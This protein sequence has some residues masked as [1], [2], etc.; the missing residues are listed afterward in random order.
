M[1]T[2]EQNVI[3]I[4][5][6]SK[7]KRFLA[8]L[9]DYFITF[10]ISFI[11][12]NLLVFPVA[13]VICDTQSKSREAANY[14][15]QALKMLNE[16]GFLKMPNEGASFEDSVNYSFK[17][18]LSY[19]AFDTE[20]VDHNYPDYGHK[21]N[22]EVI[23]T[24]YENVVNDTQRYIQDF[25]EVNATNQ[26]FDI[27]DTV[28]TIVLK[29][30]YKAIL[31][32]ELLEVLDESEYSLAM[33]NFRDNVFARLF[34][35]K[36]YNNILENDYVKNNVSYLSLLNESKEIMNG[37]K[38]VPSVS[39]LISILLSWSVTFILYPL[40][41]KE[42]RTITMS[43]MRLNKLHYKS[44]SFIDN[45]NVLFQSFYHFVLI[46]S[47][48]VFMP[49]L[50]FGISYCFNLPLLFVLSIISLLLTLV[51]MMFVFFNEHN[52][53]GMDILTNVVYIESNEVDNMYIENIKNGK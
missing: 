42:K 1:E 46:L 18:F 25:K 27:G 41:N 44:L 31:S 52:R 28:D 15:N 19:Y 7:W 13:K 35:I 11:I 23:R 37:L 30:D 21:I 48:S 9:G 47:S 39:S 5:P 24:Y 3:E 51:S 36:V 22:N 12:F 20:E 34:Y 4:R 6:L 38:W 49:V 32:N 29:A 26:M 10:I 33:T 14:E 50:F 2:Q 40:V 8:F 45:S 53:S 43:V 16:D 17:C